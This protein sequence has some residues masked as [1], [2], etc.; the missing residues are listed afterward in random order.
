MKFQA[1]FAALLLALSSRVLASPIANPEPTSLQ[2]RAEIPEVDSLD[3]DS[4]ESR[5]ERRVF[6][7][8]NFSPRYDSPH[9]STPHLTIAPRYPLIVS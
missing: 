4:G 8:D 2:T 1:T 9:L 3:I 7:R 6:T 5:L